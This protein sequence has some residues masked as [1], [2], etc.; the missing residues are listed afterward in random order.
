MT[1]LPFAATRTMLFCCTG[2]HVG[3]EQYPSPYPERWLT[4]SADLVPSKEDPGTNSASRRTKCR[5][6]G[7]TKVPGS[8]DRWARPPGA[9][10]AKKSAL[11]ELRGNV[12]PVDG[13]HADDTLGSHDLK[14]GAKNC[15][16]LLLH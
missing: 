5:R 11:H 4:P 16:Y 6:C 13:L 14:T 2:Q 15:S 7:P 10:W 3:H 8:T 1:G 12:P 9:T